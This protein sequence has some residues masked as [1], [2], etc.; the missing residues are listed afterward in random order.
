MERRGMRP[1]DRRAVKIIR[2]HHAA[3]THL[4]TTGGARYGAGRPQL[5]SGGS[6]GNVRFFDQKLRLVAWFDGLEQGAVTSVAFVAQ[7]GLHEKYRATFDDVD[8]EDEVEIPGQTLLMGAFDA[9]DFVVGTDH[10]TIYAF[11]SATFEESGSAEAVRTAEELVRGTYDAVVDM[12]SHPTEPLL[13]CLG[14]GGVA[15]T[16]DYEGKFVVTKADLADKGKGP[17]PTAACYRSDGRG[18][19][20]GTSNGALK[21]LDPR[22][23]ADV[24]TMR[25]GKDAV[26]MLAMADDDEYAAAADAA[27]MRRHLQAPRPHRPAGF[28]G[29][30]TRA[31][32]RLHRQVPGALGSKARFEVW[33][34]SRARGADWS[35]YPSAPRAASFGTTF[36]TR[37]R[38]AG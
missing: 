2:V 13:F 31:R 19:L 17:K 28:R 25:F 8:E 37:R 6:E 1:G 32:L 14:G 30:R 9:P 34:L 35:W 15:W 21:A 10:S 3:V 27:G 29:G 7:T 38:R 26:T 23:L 18:I 20:V 11:S 16:W 12:A 33:R 36:T 24:Q 5:V 22:T 4:G